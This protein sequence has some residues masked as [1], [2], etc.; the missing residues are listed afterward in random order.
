M[1]HYF[2]R[3]LG[4][5]IPTLFIIIAGSFFMMRLAP[6]GP[7]ARE[8][9][10]P[11]EIEANLMKAYHLDESLWQQFLRYLGGLVARRFR[12]VLQ[13][14]GLHR[15]RADRRRLSGLA[16][17]RRPR[18]PAWRWS[19]ASTL[20]IWA[21]LRQNSCVDYAVMVGGDDRHRDPELRRGA[22]P[23]PDLRRPCCGWL[24]VG[25]WGGRRN[26]RSC[27]SIALAC[28]RSPPSRA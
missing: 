5:A 27:R 12:P 22:D 3:R 25:G 6:G 18:H 20:G 1:L 28:R 11:P 16:A 21:A 13:I 24:P 23:H 10:V 9:A 15:R 19:S 8:R 7:F 4:G 17:A 2:L 14:Q 26:Y